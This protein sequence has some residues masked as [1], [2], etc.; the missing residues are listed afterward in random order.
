MDVAGSEFNRYIERNP[1][2]YKP[3][4]EFTHRWGRSQMNFIGYVER[5]EDD[6]EIMCARYDISVNSL[7][8]DN[9]LSKLS[10]LIR[11]FN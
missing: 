2:S 6:L 3:I 10:I 8:C 11:N 4:H 5:F 7:E 1:D 9:V